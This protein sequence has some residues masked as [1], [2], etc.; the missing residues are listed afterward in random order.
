MG[1]GGQTRAKIIAGQTHRAQGQKEKAKKRSCNFAKSYD[2]CHKKQK[3]A[4]LNGIQVGNP[5]RGSATTD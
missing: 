1:A 2:F 5:K 4:T 3:A